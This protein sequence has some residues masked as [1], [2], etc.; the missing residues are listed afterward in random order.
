[1]RRRRKVRLRR[2]RTRPWSFR[3]TVRRPRRPAIPLSSF[4][5]DDACG[6]PVRRR[7]ASYAALPHRYRKQPCAARKCHGLMLAALRHVEEIL[8]TQR[9]VRDHGA[10]ADDQ[11]RRHGRIFEARARIELQQ[12]Q[13]EPPEPV[14]DHG[15]RLETLAAT[16]PRQLRFVDE[17]IVPLV[18][19]LAD[20]VMVVAALE[21]AEYL[22]AFRIHER[23]VRLVAGSED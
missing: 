16:L 9:L 15:L 18:A 14:I 17:P 22:D 4:L 1:M 3:R 11:C 20:F 6:S 2:P 21:C 7:P 5:A 13:Q 19:E 10:T 8:R 12:L 23:A